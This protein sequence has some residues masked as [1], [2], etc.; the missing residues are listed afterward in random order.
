[1]TCCGRHIGEVRFK[2]GENKKCP[3]CGTLHS[4]KLQHNHFHIRPT[5]PETSEAGTVVIA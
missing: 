1:V 2:D 3:Y 5:R 4:V